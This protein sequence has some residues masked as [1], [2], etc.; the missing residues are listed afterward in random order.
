VSQDQNQDGHQTDRQDQAH[1]GGDKNKTPL[2]LAQEKL[3]LAQAENADLKEKLDEAK[4]LIRQL[5]DE[6][7]GHDHRIPRA[8]KLTPR[9]AAVLGCLMQTPAA[10]RREQIFYRIYMTDIEPGNKIVDVYIRHLRVKL[11]P[12][13][14]EIATEHARG[15]RL[16]QSSRQIIHELA[17]EEAK[18][19]RE[20]VKF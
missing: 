10:L 2:E 8:F 14:I 13:D 6:L 1:P 4:E 9:E 20:F 19:D 18:R 12:W 3:Y 15:W 16:P 5:Q 17:E 11:R 7:R